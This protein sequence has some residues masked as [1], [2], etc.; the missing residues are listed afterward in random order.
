M[1][2]AEI[3]QALTSY[4]EETSPE[5]SPLF[6]EELRMNGGEIRA[7]LV[8][9][10]DMHC[11]EIKSEADSLSRLVAQGSR[12]SRAFDLITLVTAKKHLEKAIPMLPIWWGIIVIPD[13]TGQPFKHIRK[14]QPN[15][16]HVPSVL[17]SLLNRDEALNLLTELGITR[18]F[19]SKSLYIMQAM[20]AETLPLDKLKK[21][22]QDSL[23]SR[24]G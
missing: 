4:L 10:G 5:H 7:D 17:A 19:K 2:E 21:S 18:G 20:I 9:I 15:K 13:E 12:Y 8:R 6:L 23:I 16:R 1:R 11:F 24:V 3:K 22:V 14:A